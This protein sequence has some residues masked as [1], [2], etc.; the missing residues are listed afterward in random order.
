MLTQAGSDKTRVLMHDP[1]VRVEL[2]S[3]AATAP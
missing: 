1:R 2:I 3:V